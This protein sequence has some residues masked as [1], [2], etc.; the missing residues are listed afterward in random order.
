MTCF[1]AYATQLHS[2]KPWKDCD[3][4]IGRIN[5]ATFMLRYVINVVVA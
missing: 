2:P 3:E 5:I 4:I 1:S